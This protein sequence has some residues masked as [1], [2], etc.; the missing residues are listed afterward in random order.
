MLLNS[1][2]KHDILTIDNL[3]T[4]DKEMVFYGKLKIV[5]LVDKKGQ[6]K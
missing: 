3:S 1:L 2:K 4:G 6:K 5:N